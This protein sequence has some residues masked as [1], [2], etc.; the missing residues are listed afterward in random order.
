MCFAVNADQCVISLANAPF[1]YSQLCIVY[2]VESVGTEEIH[3]A[4][5]QRKFNKWGVKNNI[6]RRGLE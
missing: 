3:V 4:S 1:M 6:K 5:T 2:Q